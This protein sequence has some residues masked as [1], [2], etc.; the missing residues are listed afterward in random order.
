MI[1]THTYTHIHKNHTTQHKHTHTHATNTGN[2]THT[3]AY[4]HT[5][6]HKNRYTHIYTHIH[7]KHMLTYFTPTSI[8][9]QSHIN[10]IYKFIKPNM[11]LMLSLGLEKCNGRRKTDTPHAITVPGNTYLPVHTV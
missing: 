6:T 8:N 2:R 5:H 3:H 10:I 9:R 11:L 4:T 1:T 7:N